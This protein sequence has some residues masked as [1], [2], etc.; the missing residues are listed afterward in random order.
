MG[1]LTFEPVDVDAF[2][3][4][5]LAREAG[6]GW[7]DGAV[8]AERG[9]RGRGARV[10]GGRLHFNGIPEVIERTLDGLPVAPVRALESLYEADREARVVAGEAVASVRIDKR[11]ASGGCV[12][13]VLR[14]A[15]DIEAWLYKHLEEAVGLVRRGTSTSHATFY[16]A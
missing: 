9:E 6:A 3:C 8:R 1:E 12:C 16:V 11:A 15:S 10:P 14:M 5:R 4:L 2:P 7:G 13:P